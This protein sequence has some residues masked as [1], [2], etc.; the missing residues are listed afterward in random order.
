MPKEGCCDVLYGWLGRRV[1]A[2]VQGGVR[3]LLA[4]DANFGELA[5]ER[6]ERGRGGG[7]GDQACSGDCCAA[8]RAG[9]ERSQEAALSQV[10]LSLYGLLV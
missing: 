8:V 3:A 7:S 10:P 2:R 6:G 1:C 9:Q 4:I 5:F